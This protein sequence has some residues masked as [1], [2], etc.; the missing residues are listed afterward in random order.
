MLICRTKQ[1]W[2]NSTFVVH[3][4]NK[5]WVEQSYG[6]LLFI[7]HYFQPQVRAH[8]TTVSP[9][10]KKS[11][12]EIN[13]CFIFTVILSIF[14]LV[15]TNRHTT[16]DLYLQIWMSHLCWRSHRH[17]SLTYLKLNLWLSYICHF[18]RLL[19]TKCHLLYI[20]YIFFNYLELLLTFNIICKCI[21]IYVVIF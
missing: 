8:P 14:L 11:F 1:L 2:R 19:L 15:E 7:L 9:I 20:I 12:H 4:A 16:Y 17:W 5:K 3:F 21:H 6:P 13:N 10:F 18:L